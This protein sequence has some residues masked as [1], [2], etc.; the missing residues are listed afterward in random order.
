MKRSLRVT[1]LSGAAAL[2]LGLGGAAVPAFA[3]TTDTS[4]SSSSSSSSAVL[5]Q[6]KQVTSELDTDPNAA[7]SLD[8][9]PNIDFGKNPTPNSAK[10]AVY[11]ALTADAAVQVSNPGV[12]SG[13]SVQVK[14]S[15][16]VDAAGDTLGGAVLSLGAPSV[17]A[18]NSGNPSAAP[19]PSALSLKGDG[20]NALLLKAPAKGGL[21]V[22]SSDFSLGEITL[23]V[24][25]GQLGGS[26]SSTLT[27]QL[28]D[29]V[30]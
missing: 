2:I 19:V 3:A 16:F 12:A 6:S 30:Q 10:N 24:P 25:A 20:A 9:A 11:N 29:T 21:G 27:F 22:W 4:S 26:Y 23:A 13:Y 15:P 7:I 28:S 1:L 14:N 5:S 8:S 18:A 17:E